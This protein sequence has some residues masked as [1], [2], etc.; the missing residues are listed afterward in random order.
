MD[1]PILQREQ[2]ANRAGELD[3]LYHCGRL[4]A[5]EER[6][7]ADLVA[8]AL[9]SSYNDPI[10]TEP[11]PGFDRHVYFDTGTVTC[12]QGLKDLRRLG[13]PDHGHAV[14]PQVGGHALGNAYADPLVRRVSGDIVEW[15][16]NGAFAEV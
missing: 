9:V 6:R 5:R 2:F 11:S 10:C 12:L 3:R 7:D 16:N 14:T 1:Q 13:A 15:Q 8:D 4:D